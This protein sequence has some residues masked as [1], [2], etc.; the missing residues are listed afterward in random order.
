MCW[1]MPPASPLGDVGLADGVEQRGLAVVDVAHD[2]DHRRARHQILGRVLGLAVGDD[3]VLAER[4]RLDLVAELGRDQRRRVEVD[5]LV[6]VD[7]HHAQRPQLLDDLLALDAHLLGEVGDGDGVAHAH[8]AL[9]LGG[10]RDLGLLDLLAGGGD[11]LAR[12]RAWA[13]PGRAE[14][15]PAVAVSSRGGA[16]DEPRPAEAA[17][18][19]VAILDLDLGNARLAARRHA[20]KLDEGARSPPI[21]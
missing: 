7:A 11:L 8:D 14:R 19:F 5:V 16:I 21:R 3:L 12:R 18:L 20:G 4:R 17:Q 2:G 15:G 1:V 10:R 6:D 13:L 9:V